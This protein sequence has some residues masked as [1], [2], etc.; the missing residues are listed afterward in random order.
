M[1]EHQVSVETGSLSP[2]RHVFQFLS[3]GSTTNAVGDYEG[4]VSKFT[5]APGP[6]QVFEAYR[7]IVYIEDAGA[8]DSGKY[9]NN[10][11]LTN[12]IRVLVRD[13]DDVIVLELDG[14]D[15]VK[16]NAQ[17]SALC[18][19]VSVLN[20]GSGNDSVTVRWTFAKSGNEVRI[21]GSKGHY[22]SIELN[23]DFSDLVKH[24]FMLQGWYS[25]Y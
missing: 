22:L 11:T 16:T 2:E 14:G 12:G 1:A 6:K 8:P 3:N 5:I 19:D 23:D 25:K 13:A 9:G 24:T 7:L 21:D 10:V 20:W 18:Y 4:A 15:A 17:W